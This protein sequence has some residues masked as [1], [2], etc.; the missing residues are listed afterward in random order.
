MGIE[1]AIRRSSQQNG[2]YL[3][4]EIKIPFPPEAQKAAKTL[5]DL[6]MDK[7]VDDFIETLNHGA[8]QASAKATPIFAE[9]ISQ[10]SFSDVYAIWR[11]SDDAAT[12]YLK[13]QTTPQL[14]A[15][16]KPV[17]DDALQKVEITKPMHPQK[18]IILWIIFQ[19]SISPPEVY[20]ATAMVG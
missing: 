17:I 18:A 9:A 3:N 13:A 19:R 7:L 2:F 16:F 12:Q 11:G 1:N 8:E 6:G 5:R 14:K 4:P 15:A 10:M 20:C